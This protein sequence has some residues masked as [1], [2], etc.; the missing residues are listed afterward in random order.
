MVSYAYL[1]L[2]D[3]MYV[4]SILYLLLDVHDITC[5]PSDCRASCCPQTPQAIAL[6]NFQGNVG[7]VSVH[8]CANFLTSMNQ[9]TGT[10]VRSLVHGETNNVMLSPLYWSG[11]AQSCTRGKGL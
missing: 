9:H 1:S 10:A 11:D 8:V 3:V 5:R 7:S 2:D 4:I 6:V